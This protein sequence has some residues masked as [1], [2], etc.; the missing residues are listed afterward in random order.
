[1]QVDY[2]IIGQGICGTFLSW[3]LI[4][5]GKNILV[6]DK[7]S[8]QSAS[9]VASGIINPV[10]G[11]RLART[12]MIDEL[13]PFAEQA[14]TEIGSTLGENVFKK[15]D[16][17]SFHATEQMNI[18]WNER[19]NEGEN[20][21][22]HVRQPDQ[23]NEYFNFQFGVGV[24][25]PCLLVDL[26]VLLSGWRKY[27][28]AKGVLKEEVFDI[29]DCVFNNDSVTYNGIS[30]SKIFLCNGVSAFDNHYFK[31]LPY[32]FS[33]G[34]AMILHIPG[35]PQ[36]NIYKKGLTLVPL[37]NEVFWVG[38][39]FEWEF[40]DDQPTD[41]FR[42]KVNEQLKSWLKLPYT[43]LE[44]KASLRPGSL[45]RRPFVGFHP[46]VQSLGIF[47]GMGTKGCSL[48]PYFA[49]QICMNILEGKSIQKEANIARFPKLLATSS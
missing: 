3:N 1:M 32:A 25:H 28:Q 4:N 36:H 48:A 14:Y 41:A 8:P 35:L 22:Q 15:I 38:S 13:L 11:R 40:K 33:K 12:W 37:G 10:T 46:T 39:T 16:T 30:A 27:L 49:N 45:E 19:I 26:P 20:Y 2:I 47:S 18:A 9:R 34:E 31:K 42:D 29:R 7:F 5:A 24:T 21:L 23:Y 6:I 17:V 43:I 44:H